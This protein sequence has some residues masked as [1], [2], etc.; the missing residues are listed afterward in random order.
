MSRTACGIWILIAVLTT[1]CEFGEVA[2]PDGEPIVVVQAVMRPDLPRQWILVEQ[3]LTGLQ[4]VDS[5]P[6][7]IPGD[8]PQLP[9]TG[10]TV[11][12]RNRSYLAD[13]CGPTVF[14]ER[15]GTSFLPEAPGLYWGPEGCPTMRT[16]DTLDLSVETASGTVVSGVTAIPG[17][18]AIV[19]R[20]AS[21]SVEMPGAGL[22][23]NRDID[24]LRAAAVVPS[25]RAMQIEVRRPD[26]TGASAPGFWIVVD[27][28]A[29]SVPGNLPDIL[30]A[31][32]ENETDNIPDEF[33]PVFAAGRYYRVTVG[34]TDERYFDFVRSANIPPSGR[35][36]VN[37]L[38]G[39]MG[40]FGSMVAATSPIRV[41]GQVD[42]AREGTYRLFGTLADV[43][44]DV[45]LELY[46][47][48]A[49]ADSTDASAFVLGTW[50]QGAIDESADGAFAGDSLALVIRQVVPGVA[51]SVVTLL[52]SGQLGPGPVPFEAFDPSLQLVGS[53]TLE[54][55]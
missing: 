13:P 39:G 35:G 46:V 36:F 31:F 44:V 26:V 4:P 18:E 51:D 7:A 10:A 2:V 1:G 47:G 34:L 55:P 9:V 50:I 48:T 5:S 37:R 43:P 3:T 21:D 19:L 32:E 52:L 28:T 14:I 53:L 49:D 45:S 27:S 42:D 30:T 33:P 15:P 20:T 41:I 17:A 6:I 23:L 8:G 40:V 22:V 38:D 12:V 29:I 16:G 24:T 11:T 25:G 54:R